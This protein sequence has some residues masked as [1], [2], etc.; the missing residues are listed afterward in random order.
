MPFGFVITKFQIF[1]QPQTTQNDQYVGYDQRTAKFATI[2]IQ[3]QQ[4]I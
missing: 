4:K 2:K 3:T 1:T